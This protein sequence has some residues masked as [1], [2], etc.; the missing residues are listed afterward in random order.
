MHEQFNWTCVKLCET[1]LDMSVLRSSIVLEPTA[2]PDRLVHSI[3]PT[4]AEMT[5]PDASTKLNQSISQILNINL[6]DETLMHSATEAVRVPRGEGDETLQSIV[7]QANTWTELPLA[8]PFPEPHP[9]HNES[10]SM[11]PKHC[12]SYLVEYLLL[13]ACRSRSSRTVINCISSRQPNV[14]HA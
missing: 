8:L 13:L 9:D 6:S 4:Q 12:R 2:R 5:L 14:G 11:G 3:K 7:G 10:S 1:R